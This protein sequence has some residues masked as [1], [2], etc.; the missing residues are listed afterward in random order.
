MIYNNSLKTEYLPMPVLSVDLDGTIISMNDKTKELMENSEND[1]N[2]EKITSLFNVKLEEIK[3]ASEGGPYPI[4]KKNDRRYKLITYLEEDH[5]TIVFSDV[6]TLEDLKDRYNDEK[7][8]LIRIE[9]DNYDQLIDGKSG[10]PNLELSS[11]IDKIIRKW[12]QKLEASVNRIKGS[13][14]Y[15]WLEQRFLE[16]IVESKFAILDEVRELETE[17]DFPASLSIG[18]G[19]GGKGIT[20]TE[21]YANAAIDLALG[22]GGDQAVIRRGKKIEYYGGRLQTVEKSNKG[23]SRIVGN[24]LK[25]L[26]EQAGNVFIMG[27]RHA[28]VDSFGASVGISRLCLMQEKVPYIVVD[29]VNESLSIIY[30]QVKAT[31]KYNIITPEE[32]IKLADEESLVIICDTDIPGLVQCPELLEICEKIAV[33]DHHRKSKNFI[34]NPT[35]GYVESYASST[36]ELVTEILQYMLS[37]RDLSKIEAEA[38]LAGIIVDTNNFSIKTGVRT[39]DAAAWLRRQGADPTE[40]KR[41]FQESQ[42]KMNVRV[43]ALRNTEFVKEGVGIASFTQVREQAQI[44]CAQIADQLL[45]LKGMKASFAVGRNMENQTVISARSFGDINV[46]VLMENFGGGGHLTT[47]AAQTDMSVEETVKKIK[48]LVEE[49]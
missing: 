25:K 2:G 30:E 39:F 36:C 41:F 7:P 26:V 45:T 29:E 16:K 13:S 1:E 27:H 14:Y 8:C 34:E 3:A 43:E 47:A 10:A 33:I 48:E 18:I 6:T 31:E 46:Q 24:A 23:K 22:R 49:I 35:L 17:A 32:A 40:V 4:I 15:I 12:A 9:I 38:L 19:V 5:F 42:E 21:N 11:E 20:Q 37:K 44:I 28:D